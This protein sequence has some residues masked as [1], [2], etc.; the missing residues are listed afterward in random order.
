M[1]PV[2]QVCYHMHWGPTCG[3]EKPL[4]EFGKGHIVHREDF[5][6]VALPVTY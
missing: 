1:V 6:D 3:L 4:A 5:P 2:N